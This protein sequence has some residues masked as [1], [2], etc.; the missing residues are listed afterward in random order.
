MK[1]KIVW[2]LVTCLMVAA[3]LLASCAPAVVEEEEVIPEEEEE[4]V[5]PEEEEEVIPEEEKGP[6]YGGVLNLF[7]ATGVMGFDDALVP[8][9]GCNTLRHTNE[10][11]TTGDWTKGP[12]GTGEYMWDTPGWNPD[13][14]VGMLAESWESPDPQTIIYHIR[15]G[16]YWQDKPPVNGRELTAD[17]VVFSIK[18]QWELPTSYNRA[19][20]PPPPVSVTAPDKYTVVVK[21]EPGDDPFIKTMV[22]SDYV[23]ILAPEVVAADSRDWRNSA[24][25]GPFILTDYVPMSSSTFVRNPNYWRKDPLHPGKQ[26]PYID[27]LRLL[28]IPDKSTQQAAMRTGKID[29]L[30]DLSTEDLDTVVGTRPDI[31]RRNYLTTTEYAVCMRVDTKPFDDIR[32]R[33]A[34]AMAVNRQEIANEFYGGEADILAEVVVDMPEFKDI[35][36]PL[37]EMPESV[38]ELYQYNPAKARQ[39]LAEAGYPDGFKTN[40][41]T[42][43]KDV[44]ILSIYKDYWEKIGVELELNVN[45]YGGYQYMAFRKKYTQTVYHYLLANLPYLLLNY[46]T[47]AILNWSMVDDERIEETFKL[48]KEAGFDMAKKNQAIRDLVPY[49]LDQAWSVVTPAPYRWRTW[50]PWL[51]GYYGE[52]GAG[53]VNGSIWTN[54]IW[55][56]QELKKSMGY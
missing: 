1:K 35:Y 27:G 53:C 50:Q 15:K 40:V 24:G 6:T 8:P 47:G 25:T 34:L 12:G 17:D 26:L 19:S 3:L 49:I 55:I 16:V 54:Y 9:Y 51:K 56:D 42:Y 39:L 43:P 20:Y 21:L 44:D 45:E 28:V 18:R 10:E 37:I 52:G 11:L 2:L 32:V 38:Q 13:A 48:V 22:S 5:I 31:K 23:Y 29:T 36:R 4:E 7:M 46:R 30:G 14:S 33:R 41:V